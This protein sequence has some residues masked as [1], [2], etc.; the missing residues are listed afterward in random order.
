MYA[1]STHTSGV[2]E[3]KN[4]FL[5]VLTLVAY[6]PSKN[7]SKCILIIKHP[8]IKPTKNPMILLS[9]IQ[10][11]EGGSFFSGLSPPSGM[12]GMG[13]MTSLCPGCGEDPSTHLLA[14]GG[15]RQGRQQQLK[16][17]G[18]SGFLRLRHEGLSELLR[19]GDLTEL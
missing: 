2:S 18:P 3:G 16:S 13:H 14:P 5:A 17:L 15:G 7:I 8:E 11:K 4:Y 6:K 10:L 9:V 12:R 1:Y 19:A